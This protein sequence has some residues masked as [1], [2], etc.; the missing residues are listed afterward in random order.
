MS[1]T[2]R[3]IG[4]L[5]LLLLGIPL[6]IAGVIV[7]IPLLLGA[8]IVAAVVLTIAIIVIIITAFVVGLWHLAKPQEELQPQQKSAKPLKI[9]QSKSL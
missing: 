3:F 6:A 9:K 4:L 7:L 1:H 5:I 8:G 2:Q